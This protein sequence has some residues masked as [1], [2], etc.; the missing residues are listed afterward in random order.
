[1]FNSDENNTIKVVVDYVKE[2]S[3]YDLSEELYNK[4]ELM[5]KIEEKIG[6][7]YEAL[8]I[9]V[10]YLEFLK[11]YSIYVYG[12]IVENNKETLNKLGPYRKIETNVNLYDENGRIIETAQHEFAVKD[13]LGMHTF[14]VSFNNIKSIDKI[15]KIRIFP[16]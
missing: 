11:N 9:R 13:F 14:K 1:M 6:I 10:L 3:E 4:I 8:S 2:C 16:T 15:D 12:D 7:T 5:P